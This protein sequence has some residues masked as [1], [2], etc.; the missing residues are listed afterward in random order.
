MSSY[1]EFDNG[2]VNFKNSSENFTTNQ[3]PWYG[4]NKISGDVG[5]QQE[6]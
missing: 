6:F 1:F 2:I 3:Q 5:S 4:Q